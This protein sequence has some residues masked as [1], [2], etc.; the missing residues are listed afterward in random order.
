MD[1]E[2]AVKV[3]QERFTK[4]W[5]REVSYEEADFLLKVLEKAYEEGK[6]K[7]VDGHIVDLAEENVAD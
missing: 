2:T 7:I 6:F 4:R 5:G 1:R 3:L